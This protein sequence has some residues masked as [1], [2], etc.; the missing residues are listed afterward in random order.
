MVRRALTSLGAELKFREE[1]LRE[2]DA[3][4]LPALEAQ[5]FT[6]APP[7]LVVVVDEFAALADEVPEF[8]DGMI[9]VAQRGRSLGIHLIMATQRPTGVITGNLR[10]NTN[11]R[12]A[13]RL[14][15]E[16]DSVDV[17]GTDVAA[18][19]HPDTP[20]RAVSKSGPG[21]LV[22]FQASYA[23]GWTTSEREV[24]EILVQELTLAVATTWEPPASDPIERDRNATDIK[25]LVGSIRSA[26]VAA[27]LPDPRKPWQPVLPATRSLAHVHRDGVDTMLTFGVADD[28]ERQRQIAV[29]FQPDRDGSMVAYGT[30]GSGKS[31]FL[32]SIAIAAGLTMYGGPCHVYGL[33]FG[34]RGLSMLTELPHVGSIIQGSDHERV[35]RLLGWLRAEIDERAHR[36]SQY[37]AGSLTQYRDEA[38]KQDEPRILLLIDGIA[39]FRNAYDTSD[40]IRWVDM[41]ASI[42]SEGR[43]VGVHVVMTS[44]TRSGLTTALASSVQ[45]RLVLRLASDEDYAMLG[46]EQDVLSAKSPPGRG[47]VDG[48]EVQVAVLGGAADP[49]HQAAEVDNLAKAMRNAGRTGAPKIQ[50]L[51]EQVSLDGLPAVPFAVPV[52]LASDSLEVL[53]RAAEG[54][55]P[56]HRRGSQR[57][58]HGA[59]RS[60]LRPSRGPS[61]ARRCTTSAPSAVRSPTCRAGPLA[62]SASRRSRRRRRISP[63]GSGSDGAPRTAV[64]IESAGDYVS[65]PAEQALQQLVRVC[66]NEEHWFVAEGELSAVTTSQGFLAQVKAAREGLILQPDP[67]SGQGLLKTPLGRI[68][69]NEFPVGRGVYISAGQIRIVQVAMPGA[70]GEGEG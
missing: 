16:A 65:S 36:F 32:R 12:L 13:L 18:T 39:A 31:T 27:D 15:D 63:P 25:R 60:W 52:G 38:K 30:G 9:D 33:D 19:F 66:A 34:S 28:P 26:V 67:E 44:E 43:A 57:P 8:V 22:P 61:L 11:L 21:R 45:R 24:P 48:L 5:G 69:R 2:H 17:L 42:A 3:K 41:L 35:T 37:N 53:A 51:A 59:R 10:A 14:A 6:G 62:R 7:S 23:G 49:V 58:Q 55:V 56:A 40:R 68:H 64:F 1:L 70:D 29:A 50:K 54:A 47:V 4:D 20:G 46:V